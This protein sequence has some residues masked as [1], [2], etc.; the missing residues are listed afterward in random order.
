[1]NFKRLVGNFFPKVIAEACKYKLSHGKSMSSQQQR[2]KQSQAGKQPVNS[3]RAGLQHLNIEKFL[4]IIFTSGGNR[5]SILV[6]V[7]IPSGI[8]GAQMSALSASSA[9]LM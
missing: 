3:L 4:A 9:F 6:N 2:E 5:C 7:R 8:A 1:M